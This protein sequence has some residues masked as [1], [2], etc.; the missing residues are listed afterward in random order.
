M[1][2]RCRFNHAIKGHICVELVMVI[3]R[4]VQGCDARRM[5]WRLH[6]LECPIRSLEKLDFRRA[7]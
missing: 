2:N 7:T 6:A 5:E 3:R 4:Y 1:I